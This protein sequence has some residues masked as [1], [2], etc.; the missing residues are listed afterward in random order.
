MAPHAP[1]WKRFAWMV[2]IWAASIATLGTVAAV[3]RLCL[4]R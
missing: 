4:L 2:A 3:I 1:F